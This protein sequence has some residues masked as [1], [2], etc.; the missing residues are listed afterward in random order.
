MKFPRNSKI[1][2]SPF[3]VAPFAAVLFLLVMFL[4]LGA[5]LP[6]QGL[7]TQLTPPA[8]D[9]L[10]GVDGPT[11]VWPWTPAAVFISRIKLSPM[12]CN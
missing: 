1:L 4:L 12:S 8:A 6:V 3:E 9:N 7:R 11:V 2:R 10:P 5:L